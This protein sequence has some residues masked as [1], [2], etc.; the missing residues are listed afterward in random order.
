MR[1]SYEN[2]KYPLTGNVSVPGNESIRSIVTSQAEGDRKLL[3]ESFL[4]SQDVKESSRKT[5]RQ[6][7]D[8]FF[9]F[10]D[11]NRKA[12]AG[13]DRADIVSYKNEL[14]S[15]GHKVLTVRSYLIAVRKFYR[16]A[17]SRQ[18]YRN[19]TTG[20]K[21]PKINQGGTKEHFIKMHLTEAQ[22]ASLLLHYQDNPRNYAIV[23]LMLRTGLRT[24]EVARARIEDVT[25]RSGQRILQVWGKGMDAPDPSV[26]VILTDASY[27]PI[28]EYL[29]TRPKALGG[30]PLF[31]TEGA[32]SHRNKN[33][34]G[35]A[36]STR[37]IQMI[38]KN[39]LRS[40]GL[41]DHAYSAHSLRHTTATALLR[42]G[43][44]IMDVQRALRHESIETSMIYISSIQE[45]EHLRNAPE[46][47]LDGAFKQAQNY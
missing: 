35:E 17:E 21:T 4:A 23:N 9:H 15:S 43:A 12:L 18:L 11:K 6:S 40:I 34:C 42:H 39:G 25:Y 32:G 14:L 1:Q 29:Q 22:A 8:Q 37:L 16:W 33:H 2:K 28:R 10:L 7:L 31:V 13:L 27:E 36:M 19:I 20:V 30:E 3:I 44:S 24:I 5:Y 41:D 26:F 46:A 45:E 47:M 38:V